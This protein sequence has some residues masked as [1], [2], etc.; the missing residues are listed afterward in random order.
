MG[1]QGRSARKTNR[2]QWQEDD[3]E[4]PL[5]SSTRAGTT[6]QRSDVTKV[7][8]VRCG[9]IYSLF[10]PDSPDMRKR[11]W[12]ETTA[13]LSTNTNAAHAAANAAAEE[14]A[15]DTTTPEL[16]DED[17]KTVEVIASINAELKLE[18]LSIGTAA[19]TVTNAA[20]EKAAA[21]A[22]A[23]ERAVAEQS[24]AIKKAAK[25]AKRIAAEQA[26]MDA[27][28]RVAINAAVK[29]A[30]TLA[31]SD[32]AVLPVAVVDAIK[33]AAINADEEVDVEVNNLRGEIKH[34]H[35]LLATKQVA[36]A[37]A[38]AAANEAAATINRMEEE[39]KRILL[40]FAAES[41]ATA[42]L[43]LSSWPP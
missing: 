15:A 1:K 2:P 34:L 8:V 12:K 3:F 21:G 4:S 26:A 6:Y 28:K 23:T 13:Q 41:A 19:E 10:R 29:E 42:V 37:D 40:Q 43:T 30:V 36:A 39:N 32:I 14:A 17:P 33:R 9:S 11:T 20:A 5:P 16:H 24:V 27:I 31:E 35:L 25:K 18:Q 38:R 7:N 22:D